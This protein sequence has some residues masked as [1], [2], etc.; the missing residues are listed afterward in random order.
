MLAKENLIFGGGG[1]GGGGEGRGG[2]G[3]LWPEFY[4]KLARVLDR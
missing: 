1:G 2:I 3:G 4:R